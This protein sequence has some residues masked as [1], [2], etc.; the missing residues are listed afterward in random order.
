LID[1]VSPWPQ[2]TGIVRQNLWVATLVP[3]H[4]LNIAGG[5]RFAVDGKTFLVEA[6]TRG[7]PRN[8]MMRILIAEVTDD[9]WMPMIPLVLFTLIGTAFAVDRSLRPLAQMAQLAESST[10][11][12]GLFDATRRVLPREVSTFVDAITSLLDRVQELLAA[13]RT[14]V[15]RAA[16]E[17]RTPLAALMLEA[18]RSD[19]SSRARLKSDIF[20]LSQ[21]VDRLLILSRLETKEVAAPEAI[22]LEFVAEEIIEQLASLAISTRHQISLIVRQPT[23]V[24]A[25]ITAVQHA[26]RNLIQNA[27]AHTPKGTDVVV[28]VGPHLRIEVSDNGQGWRNFDPASHIAPFA[29]GAGSSGNGLGLSIVVRA[30]EMLGADVH[31]SEANGGGARVVVERPQ[32]AL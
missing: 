16:H 12:K 11:T 24:S 2:S 30:A 21:M 20:R 32:R 31:W 7:D 29:V 4:R 15:A 8:S 25:D 22:D 5:E 26:L 14:F 18:D 1:A 23:A 10:L 3:N 27:L 6:A 28:S 13:Q 19:G 17:L 9:V